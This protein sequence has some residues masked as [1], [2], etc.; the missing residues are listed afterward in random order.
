MKK[1]KYTEYTCNMCGDTYYTSYNSEGYTNEAIPCSKDKNNLE[2]LHDYIFE[3]DIP[4]PGYGSFLDG[5]TLDKVHI[6]DDCLH[7]LFNNLE[8]EPEVIHY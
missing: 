5:V 8:I 3:F 6:C 7:T 1:I 2:Y 4:V